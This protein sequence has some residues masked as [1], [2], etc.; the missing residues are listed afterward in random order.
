MG[1]GSTWDFGDGTTSTE[2]NPL[3]EYA[4]YGVYTVSL[5]SE[6][7]FGSHKIV[8]ENCINII[9]RT[10]H[11]DEDLDFTEVNTNFDARAFDEDIS[12]TEALIPAHVVIEN[13][14]F[15]QGNETPDKAGLDEVGVHS[16]YTQVNELGQS[17]HNKLNELGRRIVK[18]PT[19]LK[20]GFSVIR[21]KQVHEK[22]KITEDYRKRE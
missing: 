12:Y 9:Q 14:T 7:E 11:N 10:R 1:Y 5:I 20:N 13:A 17:I 21:V 8:R 16:F 19:M 4:S 18:L 2:E 22:V 6:N 3:H 15:R